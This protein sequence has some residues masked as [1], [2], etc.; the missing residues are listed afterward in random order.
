[1]WVGPM[2]LS[3]KLHAVFSLFTPNYCPTNYALPAKHVLW[4]VLSA[5]TVRN[6]LPQPISK[7]RRKKTTQKSLL[8]VEQEKLQGPATLPTQHLCCQ[9]H[10]ESKCWKGKLG[11]NLCTFFPSQPAFTMSFCSWSGSEKYRDN[12]RSGKLAVSLSPVVQKLDREAKIQIC[13]F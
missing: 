6:K 12:F 8:C 11:K 7:S 4:P 3:G 9:I 1:M 10:L 5:K 13:N 2:N